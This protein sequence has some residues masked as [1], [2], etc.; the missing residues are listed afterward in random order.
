MELKEKVEKLI[1][2]EIEN[3]GYQLKK[4]EI[5]QRG[6]AKEL[7]ITIDKEGGVSVEDCA[8]VSRRID[9]ILEEADLFERRWYLTVSSPG[10]EVTKEDLE[11]LKDKKILNKK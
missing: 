2:E 6:R 5:K 3:L 1:K 7:I 11:R 8:R 10:S 9:P 4:I